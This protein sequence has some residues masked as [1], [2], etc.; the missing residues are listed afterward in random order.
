MEPTTR[1]CTGVPP[2][3]T[4][5][6]ARCESIWAPNGPDVVVGRGL[7]K[8][9][10]AAV[11]VLHDLDGA[12]S[13]G[14]LQHRAFQLAKRSLSD[15]RGALASQR[16]AVHSRQRSRRGAMLGR[17]PHDLGHPLPGHPHAGLERVYR[18]RAPWTTPRRSAG[19]SS[20]S[21]RWTQ[22]SAGRPE[23]VG[24]SSTSK[25]SSSACTWWSSAGPMPQ[26]RTAACEAVL[27]GA[28][29]MTSARSSPTP[30]CLRPLRRKV[31]LRRLPEPTPSRRSH[32]F[33]TRC[34]RSPLVSSH[35][36]SIDA[37]RPGSARTSPSAVP[38]HRRDCS[39]RCEPGVATE[40]S[41]DPQ[42][43]HVMR[44]EWSSSHRSRPAVR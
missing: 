24:T 23:R 36:A 6:T 14:R 35:R 31:R 41:D 18:V 37:Q 5:T 43:V 9:H 29:S 28:A 16:V 19:S 20:R 39:C 3:G 26:P 11:C 40:R 2:A 21:S 7:A 30:Q 42:R 17:V 22:C 34:A 1:A 10:G 8:F 32:R 4:V 13:P 27:P 44:R 25:Q 38:P 15:L 33:S 12:A